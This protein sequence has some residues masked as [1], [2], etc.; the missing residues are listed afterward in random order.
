MKIHSNKT[1]FEA[2]LER[3]RY[4][5]DEFPNIIV[6]YSGGKD[7][8]IIKNLA[9]I[10]ARERGRLPL[11][12]LFIDQEAEWA[13]VIEHVRETM[14]HPDVEPLWLQI[15]IKLFNAT[16]TTDPWLYC[17]DESKRDL[18][19][20]EQD[21][22]S[23][24]VNTY[25]TDRF[26]EMFNAFVKKTYDMPTCI[27]GG[28]RTEESPTRFVGMTSHNRY[29]GI[30]YAKILDKKK[31][32]FTFYPIYDW[33]YTDVWKAIHDNHW[34]YCSIYDEMYRHGVGI[35]DMRVS[36]LHHETAVKNLFY[37]QELEGDT[38]NRL[39]AR[40]SGINTVGQLKSEATQVPKEL[41]YMFRDWKEYRDYLLENLITDPKSR[42][43]FETK[44]SSMDATYKDM[45]HKHELYKAQITAIL[46]ND[47]HLTKLKNF[48]NKFD[49]VTYRKFTKGIVNNHSATNKLING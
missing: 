20:H 41:P 43:T 39:T 18:W 6:G 8:D 9:L 12:V 26:A 3:I 24:K 46:A 21:P 2:A 31:G 14:Y 28:I 27:L 42:K 11:K 44:F 37:L 7:S 32:H 38:W 23:I 15:P 33:S 16:S 40:L 1:V 29:K 10:V 47:Y 5:F 45:H 49:V 30:T 4:L 35:T 25:G 22:I 13:S 48:E 36:N 19:I 17:W 34:S